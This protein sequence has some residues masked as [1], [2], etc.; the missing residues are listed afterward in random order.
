MNFDLN[1]D[2]RRHFFHKKTFGF[3]KGAISTAGQVATSFIPGTIDDRL[4]GAFQN[5][6]LQPSGGAA[7]TPGL[8]ALP[9]GQAPCNT[10]GF[11]R[12]N[13]GRCISPAAA[14]INASNFAAKGQDPFGNLLPA[15]I[16]GKSLFGPVAGEFLPGGSTGPCDHFGEAV[17]G[18]YGS[19]LVPALCTNTTRRCPK[20]AVLGN[21]G[22]CY[23]RKEIT[24]KEREWPR[25]RKPL[26][27]GGEMRAI[28]TA[29]SAA[30]RLTGKVAQL[31]SMGMISS[32]TT[33]R[34]RKSIPKVCS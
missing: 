16:P 1:R 27:S 20:G 7:P 9:S 8:P 24:N 21:D 3:I 13:M 19:G 6:F 5:R 10:P 12:N 17:I 11:V 34:R 29:A 30:R 22:I 23:N 15:G 28:S 4:F 14:A 2:D 32:G 25:G 18:R 31:Q 33:K 26:L